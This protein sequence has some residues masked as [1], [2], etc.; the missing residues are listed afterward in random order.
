[1]REKPID[2]GVIGIGE[3]GH[4]AFND[5]PADFDCEEA[6][7]I[8]NL[9]E[10]CKRQQV[11][12]GWFATI[13]DVPTQAITMCVKEILRSRVIV[14]CVPHGVKADAVKNTLL[15][16]VTPLVPATILKTHPSWDLF[17]DSASASGFAIY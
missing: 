9:D 3:N 2:V 1:L 14:S 13:D 17:L 6:F 7:K 12:E 15:N 8:V 4:V 11:G 10:K 16:A 5:P